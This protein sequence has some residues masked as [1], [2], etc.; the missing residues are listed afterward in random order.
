MSGTDNERDDELVRAAS[1][2]AKD[3]RPQRDLW[4]GIAREIRRPAGRTWLRPVAQAAALM[5]LVGGTSMITYLAVRQ[6]AAPVQQVAPELVFEQAAFGSNY[7]LG[8]DYREARGNVEADLDE[9]IA[10]LSPEARAEVQENLALIRTAIADINKALAGDPDN[11][12][13]QELLMKSYR[14]ELAVMQGV[15]SLTQYV[16]SRKDI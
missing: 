9:E 2:L 4:P 13:L 7:S 12:L 5:L 16:M 11:A 3:I 8:P 15:G 10:R 14:D 6:D 1:R